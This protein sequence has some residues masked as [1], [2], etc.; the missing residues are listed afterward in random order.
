MQKKGDKMRKKL[1]LKKEKKERETKI[2]IENVETQK[3]LPQNSLC[4]QQQF[5]QQF[6]FSNCFYLW[7]LD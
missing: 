5:M 3:K 7:L 2:A 6:F 4:C 1:T